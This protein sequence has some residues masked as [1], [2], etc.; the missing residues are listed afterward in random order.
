MLEESQWRA[1]LAAAPEPTKPVS[2]NGPPGPVLLVPSSAWHSMEQRIN[3]LQTQQAET[4]SFLKCHLKMEYRRRERWAVVIQKLARGRSARRLPSVAA[5]RR[6][7]RSRTPQ[8]RLLLSSTRLHVSVPPGVPGSARASMRLRR[9]QARARGV[10]VRLRVAIF[11]QQR[12]AASM[13]QAAAR[14]RRCRR[15]IAGDLERHRLM[16]RVR[17]LEERLATESRMREDLEVAMRTLWQTV[18]PVVAVAKAWAREASPQVANAALPQDGCARE[19]RQE[20]AELCRLAAA[21]RRRARAAAA[22]QGA[23]RHRSTRAL[24]RAMPTPT[25]PRAGP[26]SIRL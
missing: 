8:H 20:A 25:T 24:C 4:G 11:I 7:W 18:S 17:S 15:L 14:G 9:L 22:L 6:L 1:V 13:L 12:A 23:W 19:A 21:Q 5:L 10:L 3:Q 16:L 2:T 26:V